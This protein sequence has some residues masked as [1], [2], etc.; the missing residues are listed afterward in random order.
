[1]EYASER[2]IDSGAL[3]GAWFTIARMSFEGRLELTRR[4]WHLAGKVEHLEAG[5][6]A[7][8]KLEAAL[9]AGEIDREYLKWG[10]RTVGGLTV[11]GEEATPELV[12]ARGP[13]ALCREAVAAIK[14]ECGLSA[15]EVK[16]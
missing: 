8:A 3:P 9:V 2:R 7:R 12:I 11:D 10:L 13:E 5:G 14:A 6:D 15:D 4:I 16:N 1:M